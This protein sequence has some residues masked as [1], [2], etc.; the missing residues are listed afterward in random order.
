[1]KRIISTITCL[2]T[3]SFVY[4]LRGQE[5]SIIDGNDTIRCQEIFIKCSQIEVGNYIIRNK[6]E[7]SDLIKVKQSLPACSNYELPAI[8]FDTNT[9]IGI[10]TSVGGCGTPQVEHY[11]IKKNES[12]VYSLVLSIKE[13]GGCEN[14]F[15]LTLWCLIPKIEQNV[16]VDFRIVKR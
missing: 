12:G 14:V 10:K 7:Y 1:M 16:K 13:N 6:I 11:V 4:S 15:R 3:F 9:L 8:D 5:T 2:L